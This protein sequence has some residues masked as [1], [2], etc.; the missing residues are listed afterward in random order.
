MPS[1]IEE[2]QVVDNA[3]T[4]EP[5]GTGSGTT[6]SS[7]AEQEVLVTRSTENP[8]DHLGTTVNPDLGTTIGHARGEG[9]NG[10]GAAPENEMLVKD[11]K[12]KN[13][14]TSSTANF[15]P[16]MLTY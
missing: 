7:A 10:E 8:A 12:L 16:L 13:N 2:D 3:N 5:G 1:L 4:M 11:M 15:L 14:K 6:S 9:P